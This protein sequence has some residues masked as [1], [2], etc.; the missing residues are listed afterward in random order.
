MP[1]LAVKVLHSHS[2]ILLSHVKFKVDINITVT[3]WFAVDVQ[4]LLPVSVT[5]YVVVVAG[6]IVVDAV[7]SFVL[8]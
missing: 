7:L 8:Q 2:L 4:E 1:P 5:L 3:S 6:E